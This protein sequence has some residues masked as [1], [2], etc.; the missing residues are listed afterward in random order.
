M[1]PAMDGVSLSTQLPTTHLTLLILC[2]G[3]AL[4]FEFVNGFHDTANAVATV[5]YTNSLKPWTAVIWSGL[6]NF[7][8]VFLGGIAVAMSIIKLLPAELVASGGTGAGLAMVLA[9]LLGAIL[10]NVG[11]WYLGLPSSSSHTMIGAIL[12]VGLANSFRPGHAL[13]AGVNWAKAG[14]VGLSLLLSPMFGFGA[15]AIL[16]LLA[17]RFIRDKRLHQSAVADQP[18]PSWVRFLLIGTCTGV[19]FAHGSNDGQ[20]GVGIIMLILIATMPGAFAVDNRLHG[21]ELAKVAAAAAELEVATRR[22]EMDKVHGE[23]TSIVHDLESIAAA[24]GTQRLGALSQSARVAFRSR[25]LSVDSQ[26]SALEK[27]GVLDKTAAAHTK[28]LRGTLRGTTDYAPSWVLIAVAVALGL[29]TMIG[30]KRIVVTVGEKIGQDHITYVQGACAEL[31]A[32][33][34]IGLSAFAGLPVST[35]HVLSSGI[36]GTMVARRSK[37]QSKTVGSIGLAWVLTL[38]VSMVLSGTLFLILVKLL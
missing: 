17:Q 8:G 37:L 7:A 11:T 29:G 38:P 32:M 3:I 27:K 15:A 1:M 6:C 10:W 4:A 34:T 36:A 20:K 12:G 13:G 14:D 21:T 26:L 16:L 25:V 9:L 5:I 18:P 23:L 22:P 30:W 2:L 28:K 19:S 31:V 35:T 24:G 33:M